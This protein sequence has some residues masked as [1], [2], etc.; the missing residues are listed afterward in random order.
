MDF[1][2]IGTIMTTLL[3]AIVLGAFNSLLSYFL[4][5]CFWEGSIFGGWLPRLAKWNLKTFKP[6][7]LKFLEAGKYSPEYDNELIKEAQNMFFFKILG[8]CM[9]CSNIW[10]GVCTYTLIWLKIDISFAYLFPYLL[11]SSF[12][13]RKIA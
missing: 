1:Y 2:T 8:G 12:I 6:E 4:D 13:L 9:I 3:L 7:R 11:F 10:L 5:Y